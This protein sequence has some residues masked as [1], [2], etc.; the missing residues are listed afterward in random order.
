[1]GEL[2]AFS[3]GHALPGRG[4]ERAIVLAA[5]VEHDADAN[6]RTVVVRVALLAAAHRDDLNAENARDAESRSHS[7]SSIINGRAGGGCS[8][9]SSA[10]V[11]N[12]SAACR[13]IASR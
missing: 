6:L 13:R 1:I 12:G 10:S 7:T 5:D 11:A 3:A 8:A 2:A 9:T 4:V